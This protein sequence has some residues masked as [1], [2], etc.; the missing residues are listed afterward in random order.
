MIQG[1]R[2]EIFVK[3][4]GKSSSCFD[5]I[6]LGTM[7]QLKRWSLGYDSMNNQNNKKTQ[8]PPT[9]TNAPRNSS[10]KPA[11][12]DALLVSKSTRGAARNTRPP[13]PSDQWIH[14]RKAKH[15]LLDYCH[16]QAQKD[17][18]L[19]S[20]S[21]GN[22]YELENFSLL[23]S[24][25]K[26]SP[27]QTPHI[28]LVSPNVQFG[29][30]VS[31]G[32]EGTLFVP[33]HG[34]PRLPHIATPQQLLHLWET[35]LFFEDNNTHHNKARILQNIRTALEQN[36]GAQQLLQYFGNV[37]HPEA[38]LQADMVSRKNLPVG[39][40]ACLPGSVVHCGP[41]SKKPRTVLFFSGAPAV[42]GSR[43]S[44]KKKKKPKKKKTTAKAVEG[45]IPAAAAA[46]ATAEEQ[47]EESQSNTTTTAS[48][49]P[50]EPVVDPYQPDSQY[51]G[52]TLATNLVSILWRT[53]GIG[54]H[55]RRYLL[56]RLVQYVESTTAKEITA[57]LGEGC[58]NDFVKKIQTKKYGTDREKRPRTKDQLVEEAAKNLDLY[59][60]SD[61]FSQT[62]NVID[63]TQYKLVSREDLWDVTV[64]PSVNTLVYRHIR[65]GR[66]V[67]RGVTDPKLPSEYEGHQPD[68]TYTLTMNVGARGKL[69]DGTNGVLKDPDGDIIQLERRLQKKPGKKPPKKRSASQSVS[70]SRKKR[71]A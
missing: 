70:K 15:C 16:A 47:P 49:S 60:H 41:A 68:Q 61:P 7:P 63:D 11:Q 50:A 30:L 20:L 58:L 1:H 53:D 6:V 25:G 43:S 38:A 37:L 34:S 44:S 40:L 10:S 22:Y 59:F 52:P 17:P 27:A 57:L 21:D 31:D 4:Q 18:R 28:D 62:A 26:S 13:H 42:A 64:D 2:S 69:F 65:D 71:K 46:A 35:C 19:S 29:L 56:H 5:T 55:E 12:G 45:E 32:A 48:S 39:T 24:L 23:V 9:R 36:D 66:I 67:L 54:Y 51:N 8:T 3:A 14:N 33:H